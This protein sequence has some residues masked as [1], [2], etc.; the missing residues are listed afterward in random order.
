[1]RLRILVQK[2]KTGTETPMSR[3]KEYLKLTVPETG[4][5]KIISGQVDVCHMNVKKN[6]QHAIGVR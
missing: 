3:R 1:M 4:A 6:V 5:V 2:N